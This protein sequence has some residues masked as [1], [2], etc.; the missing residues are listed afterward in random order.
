MRKSALFLAAV[1]ALGLTACSH[2]TEDKTPVTVTKSGIA[3]NTWHDKNNVFTAIVTVTVTDGVVKEIELSD[4]STIH[5]GTDTFVLWET[6]K[7]DYMAQYLGKTTEELLKMEVTPSKMTDHFDGGT[8][9]GCIDAIS[10]AT[11]SSVTYALAVQN[12][13][14]Q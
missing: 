8:M 5:T 9:N 14:S 2:K 13:L 10:G 7:E 3:S 1:F 12:A 4:S 6:N 11:A